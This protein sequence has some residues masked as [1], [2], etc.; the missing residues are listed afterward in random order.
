M[1]E[2]AYQR[3]LAG[4]PGLPGR[5]RELLARR[6][7]LLAR[8]R[9]PLAGRRELLAPTGRHGQGSSATASSQRCRAG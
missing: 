1:S 3:V 2:E 6:R 7:E 8:R 5:C 4:I 9:E